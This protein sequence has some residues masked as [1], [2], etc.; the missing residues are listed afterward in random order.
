MG[1]EIPSQLEYREKIMFNLTFKQLIYAFIVFFIDFC[2]FFKINASIQVRVILIVLPTLIGAGFIFFDLEKYAVNIYHWL[3]TQRKRDIKSFTKDL[4]K[5]EVSVLKVQPINFHIKTREEKDTISRQ[6][7]KF[8][9]AIDFPI[10]ILMKTKE[11]EIDEYLDNLK[12]PEN[13]QELFKDNKKFIKELIDNENVKDRVFYLI[14][15]KKDNLEIQEEICLDWLKSLNLKVNKISKTE[16]E[17]LTQINGKE[18]IN[19]PSYLNVGEEFHRIIYAHGYPRI[20]EQGFLDRIVSSIGNFDFSLHIEPYEVETMM[21]NINKELQKQKADLYSMGLKGI[22]NPSLEIQ[23]NDT[24]RVLEELQKGNNKLF[25]VSLY[26]D[27]KAKDLKELEFVTRKT[28]AMLNSLMI[29]PRKA[30]FQMDKG[31]KSIMPYGFNQLKITRNIT[32]K[33]LSAFFPFTSP[34]FESD[35]QGIWLGVNKNGIP[36]IKDIFELSNPN[37]V[38][39]AQSGGGKSFFAKLLIS[40]YLMNQT[41]VMVIDPQ[42]EYKALVKKFNGQR[43]DLSR[44][45][46][47]IINPLDL[48]GQDY[49][50]KRLSLIDLMRVMLGDLSEVQRAMLDRALTQTYKK[51]GITNKP[52]TWNRKPPILKDLSIVLKDMSRKGTSLEKTTINSLI[53]RLS[54]YVDGVFSFLNRKTNIDF[55][56]NFVCFDIGDIPRPI[57]PVIMFLVLEY[58]YSKMKGDLDRK[59]LLIDEAWS[60]LSRSEE[61]SYIF[62][63][64]KTCRKFNLGLLLINQEVEGLLNSNAGKSVLANSAYTFLM[65]QKPAVIDS[66]NKVFHLSKYER[67]FLL[68]ASIGEGLLIIDNDHF[69]MKVIASEEEHKTITT[70][71]DEIVKQNNDTKKGDE[72]NLDLDKVL[73]EISK[74][75]KKEEEALKDLGYEQK[76]FKSIDGKKRTYL[77][78]P[79]SNESLQHC[80]LT[81]EIYDYLKDKVDKIWL[82]ETVKPDVV[83]EVKGIKYAIEIETGKIGK[84]KVIKE[85]VENLNKEYGQS[86]CFVVTDRN[87]VSRYKKYG[88]VLEKRNLAKNLEHFVSK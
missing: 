45:S 35:N 38:I 63:I 22:I 70:K 82:Y 46:K 8:M 23:Y 69:E 34:F 9:N 24:R 50:E 64:V 20:V 16:F 75:K 15:P 80:I 72:V 4:K 40:R 33:G 61:A 21:V 19:K 52:S 78:K 57:K 65:K 30:T 13:Y 73:Y 83:F 12:V 79:R 67:D 43:I 2:L 87:L 76:T 54:M 56:N 59:I 32:S 37:G 10:Q 18:I 77:V 88:L 27:C 71:A 74:I 28:E 39:L 7:L 85:K 51:K 6:F 53:N 44:N 25:N 66:I 62:E 55:N 42:G 41:K 84:P 86:W 26:I 49:A 48:M 31:L 1:Y 11:L 5:R 36:I 68:T 47:T 81:F 60:L 29:I 3:V 17:S 58:V 14:I